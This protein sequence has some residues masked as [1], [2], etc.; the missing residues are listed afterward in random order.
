MD[1]GKFNWLLRNTLDE[2]FDE[3]AERVQQSIEEI[4]PKKHYVGVRYIDPDYDGAIANKVYVYEDPWGDL[5]YG[6]IV[7]RPTGKC[8]V[9]Q[10]NC[11]KPAGVFGLLARYRKETV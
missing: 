6:D 11:K 1:R 2:M 10:T 8:L 7:E 5:K 3:I 9:V 4:K